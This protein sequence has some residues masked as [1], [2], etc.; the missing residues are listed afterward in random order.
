MLNF[1]VYKQC[2]PL[3]IPDSGKLTRMP[4][5]TTR[6]L[7]QYEAN[8]QEIAR[9]KAWT[10]EEAWRLAREQVRYPV[11]EFPEVTYKTVWED[12]P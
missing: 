5:G 8:L 6:I 11:V 10:A 1:I 9:G 2:P 12:A 7:F 4:D 3:P